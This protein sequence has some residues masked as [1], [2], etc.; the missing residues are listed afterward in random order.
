MRYQL[1][2]I[3]TRHFRGVRKNIS[4]SHPTNTNLHVSNRIPESAPLSSQQ[5]PTTCNPARRLT[6][7]PEVKVLV[8]HPIR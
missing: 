4:R 1:R 8:Y 5:L 3:R 7:Q 2:Y 6:N